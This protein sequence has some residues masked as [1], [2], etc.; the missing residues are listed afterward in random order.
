MG[1]YDYNTSFYA[2][3]TYFDMIEAEQKNL[4]LLKNPR[5]IHNLEEKEKFYEWMCDTFVK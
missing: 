5:I 2:A 4:L 1:K 3:K